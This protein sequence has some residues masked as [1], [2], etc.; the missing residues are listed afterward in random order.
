MSGDQQ[1]QQHR[2][3]PA[4]GYGGGGG[5]HQTQVQY[6]A[7]G[8]ST[9][10]RRR[11][12]SNALSDGITPAE[13]RSHAGP[14]PARRAAAAAAT[15]A[16]HDATSEDEIESLKRDMGSDLWALQRQRM[17]REQLNNNN[18]NRQR[19]S[20]SATESPGSPLAQ[21]ASPV[22]RGKAM[23]HSH[24]QQPAGLALHRLEASPPPPPPPL[25][26]ADAYA[27]T[28]SPT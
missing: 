8:M 13:G 2:H 16:D 26:G 20:G 19:P 12:L 27:G 24:Y 1:Q 28:G 25:Y 17:R 6:P 9:A 11:R 10:P 23:A 18:N 4:G 14:P 3:S 15:Y 22:A 21:D 5:W 7:A